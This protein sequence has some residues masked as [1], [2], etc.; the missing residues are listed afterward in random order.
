MAIEIP[1]GKRDLNMNINAYCFSNS[2][3]I[4]PFKFLP[5]VIQYLVIMYV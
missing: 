1:G 2:F 5:F 3:T 4:R